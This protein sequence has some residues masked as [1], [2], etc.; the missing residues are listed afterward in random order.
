ML[1]LPKGLK[2]RLCQGLGFSS[3]GRHLTGVGEIGVIVEPF[4]P[5]ADLAQ[6]GA[7]RVPL[8]F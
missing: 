2:Q 6:L 4:G 5:V 7:K 3:F 8:F 1:D